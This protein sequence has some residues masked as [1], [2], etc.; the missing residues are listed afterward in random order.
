MWG[1]D[2]LLNPVVIP[3]PLNERVFSILVKVINLH[4]RNYWVPNAAVYWQEQVPEGAMSIVCGSPQRG[5]SR[6]TQ[7]TNSALM[8]SSG[9]TGKAASLTQKFHCNIPVSFG[10][11]G[12]SRCSLS[13]RQLQRM[14]MFNHEIALELRLCPVLPW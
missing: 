2:A 6:E 10:R 4:A 13:K 3:L 12:N 14:R 5:K 8:M 1:S 9:C 11:I 7:T